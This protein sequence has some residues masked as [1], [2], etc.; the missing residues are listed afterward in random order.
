VGADEAETLIKMLKRGKHGWSTTLPAEAGLCLKKR[1]DVSVRSPDLL[2]AK[3]P[4]LTEAEIELLTTI[5]ANLPT[6]VARAE[7]AWENADGYGLLDEEDRLS[8][9]CIWI[10][11]E[12]Q[13]GKTAGKWTFVIGVAKSDYAW[14]VEF[15]RNKFKEIWSGD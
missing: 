11:R 6:L 8:R 13:V 12:Q 14:H 3:E 15:A 2:G 4:P 10:D 5:F 7:K 9:P 1:I